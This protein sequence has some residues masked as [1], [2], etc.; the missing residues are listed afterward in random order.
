MLCSLNPDFEADRAALGMK[1]Q[2]LREEFVEKFVDC[3]YFR[4]LF[5]IT[6]PKLIP[7][8]KGALVFCYGEDW[9]SYSL[10]DDSYKLADSWDSEPSTTTISNAVQKGIDDNTE[11]VPEKIDDSEYIQKVVILFGIVF[12][13]YSGIKV[14]E[15]HF[16][17]QIFL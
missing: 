17:S 9:S 16:M 6:R 3:F 1:E 11:Y 14:A 4:N 13:L 7:V 5:I 2:R 12:L 8:E 10:V 15:Y